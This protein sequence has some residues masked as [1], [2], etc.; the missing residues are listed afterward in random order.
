MQFSG[1]SADRS[2]TSA[3]EWPAATRWYSHDGQ[4]AF[5]P[6]EIAAR[7]ASIREPVYLV[8]DPTTGHRGLAVG[9]G[10]I[11][12]RT[13]GGYELVGVL[14]PIYPEW[15]GDRSFC[16]TH[17]VRFPYIAGEMANGISTTRMVIA[18]ARAEMLSFFGAA[19]LD[20]SRI[21]AAVDEL[22]AAL[23]H[24][25]NWG[26]N[27]IHNANDPESEGWV[28]RTMVAKKVP[29]VSFSAFMDLTPAVVFCAASGLHVDRAGQIV[30]PTQ[31]F[32]KVSRP[33]VAAKFISPPPAEM[34]REL[35]AGGRIT[36]AEADLAARLPVAGDLTVEADSGGHTDNR[37][38]AVLMPAI[39]AMAD[40]ATA[41]FGYPLP[42]RVGAAGGLGTPA[43]VAA[44]F[45]LGAAY[46][47]TGSINAASVESG[48]S[49]DAKAMLAQA[50]LADVV[51]APSADMFELGVNV[52]VLLRGTRFAG[53]AALLY[54]TYRAYPGVDEIPSALRSKLESEIFRA[55]LADIWS[56]TEQFWRE[57]DPEQLALAETDAKHR[58]ALIFRWYLGM[59]TRWAIVG[60]SSRGIDYQLWCGPAMG[61]FNRWTDGS[62]LA[63]LGNRSVVQIA[64]NLLEG[65][66]VVTRA[67]QA[68]TV[69]MPILTTEFGFAPRPLA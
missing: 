15:L 17:G 25:P 7:V 18:M 19:G 11:T 67:H 16:D 23:G 24:L 43:A 8:A 9:G 29:K 42:I 56:A 61:A 59:A 64:L 65:A 12:D 27:V 46:V 41:R 5:A 63:S 62:F 4:P 45:G 38:M 26:V 36:Q 51:M 30:R 54:E 49:E 66:A 55:Q 2:S 37:P 1:A 48:L 47:M 58:M 21:D 31:L 40:A 13:T 60:D 28:A 52:Q 3:P 68:R 20:R 39:R 44:A 32:A 34:L 35:V 33:E 6:A 57:R 10:L 14:P 22:Q 50:D 53:R 69:G